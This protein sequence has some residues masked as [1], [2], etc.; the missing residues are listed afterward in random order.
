MTKTH[1]LRA[2]SSLALIAAMS[3]AAVSQSTGG[4]PPGGAQNEKQ[5]PAQ[6]E[7]QAPAQGEKMS[8][9]ASGTTDV[10][11]G[12]GSAERPSDRPKA[13]ERAQEKA[14]PKSAVQGDDK[15]DEPR[16]SRAAGD[17][18]KDKDD[19]ARASDERTK[20]KDDKARASGERA[21]DGKQQTRESDSKD[22]SRT[23]GERDGK[24]G[25]G[26]AATKGKAA[27]GK[28]GDGAER[29]QISQQQRT[30]V[31]ERLSKHA[32]SNR[33]TN[34][35]FDIRVGVHVP[36]SV[37]LHVLPPE[38][39]EI[40]PQY[41]GYRYVYVGEEILIID[42]SDYVIVAVLSA[43]GRAAVRRGGSITLAADDR[44][45]FRRH[46]TR[47]PAI[48][49]GIGG[50]SIGMS[51]P[52]SVELRPIPSVIVQRVP[53]LEGHRYFF[54]EDEIV[55]VDPNTRQVVYVIED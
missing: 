8:P 54:Y 3:T 47:G 17:R 23:V 25:K 5:L 9:G 11:K 20:D 26:D 10:P 12:K 1:L 22:R 14:S 4:P 48:R 27:E 2:A 16:R 21:K 24:D 38:V 18:A 15:G 13:S 49:L 6:G 32:Q 53:D 43:D 31:R 41:R 36:R 45:F 7:R 33:V 50:I 44:V 19:N 29:V 39:I 28:R 46:V 40:V 35:N 34:V 37:T 51:L 55:I 52:D 42:P 30:T